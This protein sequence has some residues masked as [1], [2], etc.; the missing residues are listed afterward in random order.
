MN[1][2]RSRLERWLGPLA[3]A[4]PLAPNTITLIALTFV[5]AAATCLAL[6]HTQP[7]LFLLALPLLAIGGLL[8]AL[9]GIVARMTGQTSRFGDFLDHFADRVADLSLVCGWCIGSNIRLELALLFLLSVSLNGYVGTQIEATFRVR[10]YEG[11]G[12]GEFVLA[13]I[14]LPLLAFCLEESNLA[15]LTFAGLHATEWAT[16]AVTLAAVA[17]VAARLRRAIGAATKQDLSAHPR[18]DD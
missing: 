13:L 18:S 4:T 3:A 9:D 10:D 11:V 5:L 17:G 1:V 14:I 8:D 15:S 7:L 6:A 12:R 16:A 2:W